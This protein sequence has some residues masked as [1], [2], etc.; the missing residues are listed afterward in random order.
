MANRIKKTDE[1]LK[2]EL[3]EL[4]RSGA[5]R[6]AANTRLGKAMA[7][8]S[9]NATQLT[10]DTIVYLLQ[11]DMATMQFERGPVPTLAAFAVTDNIPKVKGFRAAKVTIGEAIKVATHLG[12]SRIEVSEATR[13]DGKIPVIFI[14]ITER[15]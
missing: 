14:A 7:R 8:F 3:L 5:D 11:T 2:A 13:P 6:P 9:K 1:Q 12:L 4:A 10:T 15:S